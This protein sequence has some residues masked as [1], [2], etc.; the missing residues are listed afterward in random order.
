MHCTGEEECR[1]LQKQD[2]K[3]QRAQRHPATALKHQH[4]SS[5]TRKAALHRVTA[6]KTFM[7]VLFPSTQH[8]LEQG[9][10]QAQHA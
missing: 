1:E 10:M 7:P 2:A 5:K 3:E 4:L 9:F 8:Q 6:H